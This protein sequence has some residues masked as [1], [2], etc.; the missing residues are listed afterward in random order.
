MMSEGKLYIHFDTFYP[1]AYEPDQAI[2]GAETYA[3][4]RR[5]IYVVASAYWLPPETAGDP[6][7]LADYFQWTGTKL[8]EQDRVVLLDDN[9]VAAL[10]AATQKRMVPVPFPPMTDLRFRAAW[11]PH[12]N[13]VGSVAVS[14]ALGRYTTDPGVP[15]PADP[16]QLPAEMWPVFAVANFSVP[17]AHRW[18]DMTPPQ[19]TDTIEWCCAIIPR[20]NEKADRLTGPEKA[21]YE[22]YKD[23]TVL[24]PPEPSAP[25]AREVA[26]P[27]S[28]D[29]LHRKWREQL[30]PKDWDERT[31]GVP[32]AGR[33][34]ET[35]VGGGS[36][37]KVVGTAP[38]FLVD[39]AI[40]A[41]RLDLV[42]SNAFLAGTPDAGKALTGMSYHR[43]LW[44]SMK[45]MAGRPFAQGEA[46]DV[47]DGRIE[48]E[49][50]VAQALGQ[51]FGYG[52]RLR[53]QKPSQSEGAA[54][55]MTPREDSG[56]I[57]ALTPPGGPLHHIASDPQKT[58]GDW[59]GTNAHSLLGQVFR[60]GPLAD[61]PESGELKVDSLDVQELS[62]GAGIDL[63]AA[64][65]QLTGV[66]RLHIDDANEALS[67]TFAVRL[68]RDRT[69][70]NG[71]VFYAPKMALGA[72]SKLTSPDGGQI[73]E[74]P[75]VLLDTVDPTPRVDMPAAKDPNASGQENNL[76]IFNPA[77]SGFRISELY[78]PEIVSD[79]Y[80]H[81]FRAK[82]EACKELLPYADETVLR[83]TL[84]NKLEPEEWT[85]I[86]PL[87]ESLAKPGT[88][89]FW[90]KRAPAVWVAPDVA[91][92]PGDGVAKTESEPFDAGTVLSIFSTKALDGR[93][94]TIEILLR[95]PD[96]RILKCLKRAASA[97]GERGQEDRRRYLA[98]FIVN[99]SFADEGE[100]ANLWQWT[101][102]NP[103]DALPLFML[104][105]AFTS[106]VSRSVERLTERFQTTLSPSPWAAG[107]VGERIDDHF[108]NFNKLRLAMHDGGGAK[109]IFL[110]YPDAVAN[111][112]TQA[113]A[114]S[115]YAGELVRSIDWAEPP[116]PGGPH[117]TYLVPHIFTQEI[118]DHP[119]ATENMR[120]EGYRNAGRVWQLTGYVEH[121]YSYRFPFIAGNGG[122]DDGTL[123][124]QLTTDIR[125][126]SELGQR[127]VEGVV[128][129]DD[130]RKQSKQ[131][132]NLIAFDH[133]PGSPA[134]DERISIF[135]LRNAL[136]TMLIAHDNAEQQNSGGRVRPAQ[137]RELYESLLDLRFALRAENGDNQ[138]TAGDLTLLLE[139]WNFDNDNPVVSEA[140][141]FGLSPYPSI[142]ANMLCVEAGTLSL[143]RLA[144]LSKTALD[145]LNPLLDGTFEDYVAKLRSYAALPDLPGFEGDAPWLQLDVPLDRSGAT[146]WT[147]IGQ[148]TASLYKDTNAIRV[149]LTLK[150]PARVVADDTY[151]KGSFFGMT[152]NQADISRA[153][154]LKGENFESDGLRARA[155]AELAEYFDRDAPELS[156]L[157]SRFMWLPSLD[158]DPKSNP[159]MPVDGPSDPDKYDPQRYKRLFGE[160]LPVLNFP[161]GSRR[162]VREVVN[163]YYVPHAFVPLQA[164]P[165]LSEAKTTTEFAQFL[166]RAVGEIASSRLPSEIGL[167]EEV[168][169]PAT[170]LKL[171]TTC[172]ELLEDDGGIADSLAKL[173][174]FVDDRKTISRSW[175]NPAE[176]RFFEQ[177]YEILDDRDA[178]IKRALR[179]LLAREPNLFESAKGFGIG[180]FDD[181]TFSER[182]YDIEL[183]KDI[184]RINSGGANTAAGPSEDTAPMSFAQFLGEGGKRFFID[185]VDDKSYDNEFEIDQNTYE[186][187]ATHDEEWRDVD[188]SQADRDGRRVEIVAGLTRIKTRGAALGRTAE[189]HIEQDHHFKTAN[190]RDPRNVELNVVHYNPEWRVRRDKKDEVSDWL[191]IL[192]SRWFPPMPVALRPKQD[193]GE[194][195]DGGAF[196]DASPW[197]SV[198]MLNWT[199]PPTRPMEEEFQGEARKVLDRKA[200]VS[201]P[202]TG[203]DGGQRTVTPLEDSIQIVDGADAEGWH[204]IESYLSHYYF[205]IDADEEGRSADP[206]FSNDAI[207]IFTEVADAPFKKE[208]QALKSE[209]AKPV[210]ELHKWFLYS[211]RLNQGT[212]ETLPQEEQQ[213]DMKLA[214]VVDELRLWIKDFRSPDAL[215]FTQGLSLLRGRPEASA[216]GRS[217]LDDMS[218]DGDGDLYA[219]WSRYWF[220]G[221]AWKLEHKQSE[222][223]PNNDI[224]NVVAAEIFTF[225]DQDPKDANQQY[226]LRVTVLDEPWK[227][228]R[229][230]IR[231]R[232]NFRDVDG[233]NDPDINPVFVLTSPL[234]EWSDYGR[235]PLVIGPADFDHWSIPDEVSRLLVVPNAQ[236]NVPSLSQ[237]YNASMSDVKSFGP[238]VGAATKDA[239]F[240]V[241]HSGGQTTYTYWNVYELTKAA[242]AVVGTVEHPVKQRALRVGSGGGRMGGV[243][244]LEW[245]VARQFLNR[246]DGA[247]LAQLA[248]NIHKSETPGTELIMRVTWNMGEEGPVLTVTWPV[249]FVVR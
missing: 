169:D 185:V 48:G 67:Q 233:N 221:G 189:D 53:W 164:H 245:E 12:Y 64:R 163:L 45:A 17:T 144:E 182:L 141:V 21:A 222:G 212:S 72:P 135:F 216:E 201:L 6:G 52:E 24:N 87:F 18:M 22:L 235:Q 173:V 224:G 145:T 55:F 7:G 75:S 90:A 59:F 238:L 197:R 171:R 32:L 9:L 217:P 93:V 232:R 249:V 3:S 206:L 79:N 94:E 143:R 140:E 14:G 108:G 23:N 168:I 156:P 8:D 66:L 184:R 119:S 103:P 15:D 104:N 74:P 160:V 142:S 65:A 88:D 162:D 158:I 247:T 99:V 73:F 237:W 13:G 34:F 97:A 152:S 35:L 26:D 112:I 191:Y 174:T 82:L 89:P 71:L 42:L 211:R 84:Q 81:Y 58:I 148:G 116:K 36:A 149:G 25:E 231:V 241:R 219:T 147:W 165:S 68:E 19:W 155:K 46:G 202:A 102:P 154:A 105:G 63:A 186:T 132:R 177:V 78:R 151:G 229:A 20:L 39:P 190:D 220:S 100:Y 240:T 91:E 38:K 234:S 178:P 40:L 96:E 113:E 121:Q 10:D 16:L 146:P 244:E 101:G 225:D 31:N 62:V 166:V 181:V 4:E 239:T 5:Y 236:Q 243:E 230:R 205:I 242:R 109:P 213:K 37:L 11:A 126:P 204:H 77:R 28:A 159:V 215:P 54:R 200:V 209:H 134:E 129:D 51:L 29:A 157:H 30:R 130:E 85:F 110:T 226:V 41:N 187:R 27:N 150:R 176:K 120:F 192:P 179:A 60:I 61:D 124:L 137:L 248:T 210:S 227:F 57:A 136:R 161:T 172:R 43:R 80:R 193:G 125:H 86:G 92:G 44:E 167:K 139:R 70:P 180:L 188:H 69:N 115:K 175:D 111:L 123:R 138:R 127:G 118:A 95:D 76:L 49:Q 208:P 196:D 107:N 246:A 199:N 106:R 33:I 207:E 183:R 198:I 2:E 153:P 131:L 83:L 214:D 47:R 114:Q 128:D 56:R 195:G 117:Y 98:E 122:D 218:D 228:T 1:S 223:G 203:E 50:T 133:R 194:D 170:A